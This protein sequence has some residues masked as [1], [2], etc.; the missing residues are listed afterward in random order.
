[1]VVL[2]L[3]PAAIV[4]VVDVENRRHAGEEQ[5]RQTA[6]LL[7]RLVAA[8]QNELVGRTRQ[9]LTLLSQ[10]PQ[11]TG[12]DPA[13][14]AIVLQD[15]LKSSPGY[16]GF[17]VSL[18]NGDIW[19][20]AP[21][22]LRPLNVAD[23]R[24][25]QRA[26]ESRAFVI[27]GY[28]IGIQSGVGN[29]T[30][31][32]PILDENGEVVRVLGA[33]IDTEALND[34]VARMLLDLG[35]QILMLDDE[36]TIIVRQPDDE[37]LIGTRPE[38]TQLIRTI[39]SGQEGTAE[40]PNLKGE[41]YLWS[42]TTLSGLA[43]QQLHLAIGYSTDL[44][45]R[46]VG[47]TISRSLTLFILIGALL[48][49]L[50]WMLG[51]AIIWRRLTQ[52]SGAAKR[53]AQGDFRVQISLQRG[54]SELDEVTNS[55]NTMARRLQV[56]DEERNAAVARLEEALHSQ[57][58]IAEIGPLLA[59]K[60]DFEQR[61]ENLA[62]LIVEFLADWCTI[63]LLE[64][65]VGGPTSIR[66]VAAMHREPG[67]QALIQELREQF[68]PRLDT[69]FSVGNAIRTATGH[70]LSDVTDEQKAQFTTSP[71]HAELLDELGFA[72]FM[73]IP[74]IARERIL[75]AISFVRGPDSPR[76]TESDFSL[77]QV[78]AGRAA[79]ALDNARLYRQ[80]QNVNSQLEQ[81]VAKRTSQLQTSTTKLL[82]S[83]EQLRQLSARLR[84]VLEEERSR[85]SREIH[86]ELGQ[87]LTGMKMDITHV[88]K[89]LQPDQQA[90]RDRLNV[91]SRLIDDTIKTVRRIA[92]DL[93]PGILDDLGLVAALEWQCSQFE[94]RTGVPCELVSEPANIELPRETATVLFRIAQ[95]A[96]TNVA[97]HANATQVTVS[98]I[99]DEE[100]LDLE[101]SDNGRGISDTDL[102]M[103]KSLGLLG[104]TERARL[105]GG[106]AEIKGAPGKGTTVLVRLGR[107]QIDSAPA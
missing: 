56:I 106:A 88:Q 107:R 7:T 84:D 15:L 104:I 61:L 31:G 85:I 46:G 54:A 51:N 30:F 58:L 42:F 91:T 100:N 18:S 96:L 39:L 8:D 76:Y 38:S 102:Q 55:F 62:R 43:N 35:G 47:E 59:T 65:N 19:C 13:A 37:K 1:M 80:V 40:L 99:L 89:Q 101:V 26:I 34:R 6:L 4:A 86:D 95:E 52:L 75:G 93:R 63:D 22:P 36:G 20:G 71:R 32:Y 44:A 92:S 74:L 25:F 29:L 64:D 49:T 79:L 23:R 105:L 48:V 97:R 53:I 33:G 78:A 67:K 16:R 12:N 69:P 60:M 70:L 68:P 9:L 3:L 24:F 77:A 94:E 73:V 98:L 72:S 14:C 27:G 5:T 50:A 41:P 17:S 10:M 57:R 45:Y 11:I 87:S 21:T 28:S 83:R 81:L 66:Q 103:S 2:A 90:L 82:E